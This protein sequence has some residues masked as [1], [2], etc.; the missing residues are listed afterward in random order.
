MD[1]IAGT[2]L[3]SS[4]LCSLSVTD[5]NVCLGTYCVP[6]TVSSRVSCES[7]FRFHWFGLGQGIFLEHVKDALKKVARA[8]EFLKC[9]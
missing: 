9:S 7:D 4:A 6:E 2:H 5:Q 3:V 8:M 1:V